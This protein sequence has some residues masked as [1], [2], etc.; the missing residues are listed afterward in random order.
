MEKEMDTWKACFGKKEEFAVVLDFVPDPDQGQGATT[1]EFASWGSLEIW[2]RGQNLCAH[3]ED[4]RIIQS[5]NWYLL[6]FLEWLARNWDPLLHEQKLPIKQSD[7]KNTAWASFQSHFQP[8]I[9]YDDSQAA[10]WDKR[11]HEWMGRHSLLMARDGGLFPDLFLRRYRDQIEFS[12]GEILHPGAPRGF[13]FC[14]PGGFVRLP[15][16]KVSQ[17]LFDLLQDSVQFLMKRCA[18]SE[19]IEILNQTIQRIPKADQTARLAWLAG[20]DLQ[21]GKAIGRWNGFVKKVTDELSD[22]GKRLFSES[23]TLSDIVITGSCDAAMMFGSLAPTIEKEDVLTIA[24]EMVEASKHNE[25]DELLEGLTGPMQLDDDP[26]PPWEQGYNFAMTLHEE[27]PVDQ[28]GRF[29]DVTGFLGNLGVHF[30]EISLTD[31]DIRAISLAGPRHQPTILL[32]INNPT[33]QYDSGRRFTFAHELCHLLYDRTYGM[34]LAM[35]S[36]PWAPRDIEKRA[37]AFAAMF[38][39]PTHLVRELFGRL[40]SPRITIQDILEMAATLK[41]SVVGMIDHLKNIGLI[42]EDTQERLKEE[43]A[44]AHS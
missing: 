2:V 22:A 17:P 21:I 5:V 28:T 4:G 30:G 3:I 42:D 39:M 37:N 16:A 14:V 34:K 9:G 32:N 41:T 7:A 1:E 8:P 12:W 26:L 20:L 25:H 15:P 13:R 29:V 11:W 35:A 36:G 43:A 23:Q 44:K 19:R 31:S 27:M 18:G 40:T 38:T 6:S 10:E 33:N 24:R